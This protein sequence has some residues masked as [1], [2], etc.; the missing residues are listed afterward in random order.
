MTISRPTPHQPPAFR[1]PR[2]SILRI[3][4]HAAVACA[5]LTSSVAHAVSFH[6]QSVTPRCAQ[7]GTTVEVM[8]RGNCL[9]EPREVIFYRPG[10][11]AVDISC[12]K[13]KNDRWGPVRCRFEIA[14]DCPLGEHPFRL[15]T[16]TQLTTLA[17]FHVTPYPT[18]DEVEKKK[19]TNDTLETAVNVAANVTVRGM[20]DKGDHGDVDLYKVPVVPGERL[21]VEVDSVRLADV[22]YGNSEFDVAVRILD[23]DGR[24]LAANDDNPLHVQDPIVAVRIPGVPVADPHGDHAFVEVRRQAFAAFDRMYAVHIGTHRRPLAAYPAGGPAGAPLAV[25]LLGDPLGDAEETI[26]VPADPGPFEY[27]GDGPSSL[28]LRSSPFPNVLEDATL[29]ATPVVA[30]PAA[31]NGILE[32]PGDT[33]AFRMAVKKGDRYRVRVFAAALGSPIDPVIRIRP[34]DAA[35]NPGPVSLQADDATPAERDIFG[36]KFRGGGGLKDIADPSVIWEPKADGDHLLEVLDN[37]GSGA[38]TGVY[39]IEIEPAVDAVHTLLMSTA[40]DWMECP[41]TSSLAVP[42][43]NRWTVNVALPEPQGNAFDGEL[44]IVARGLPPGVRIVSPR[45]PAGQR[46]WPVQFVADPAAI[47]GGAVFSLEARPADPAKVI[48]SGSHQALPFINHSGG[49]A[50]RTVLVDRYVMAVTDPAP[51][52]ISI[53]QPTVPLVRGGELSIPVKITRREGF[54]DPI[55]FQCDWIPKGIAPQPQATIPTGESTA[56]LRI[57][58]ADNAP[59]GGVPLVVAATTTQHANHS[60]LGLG[61]I[62]VS[63]E[64]ATITVAEPFVALASQPESVRR[65]ERK[66]FAWTVEHKSPFEGAATVKLVGLPKGVSVV[67]P[68]PMIT[69]DSKDL[70]FEIEATDEALMGA[71]KGLA[72]EVIVQ[73]AGQEI[74][75]RTGSG[76]LRI[77]PKL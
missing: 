8:M 13:L 10:I 17:T 22:H 30:L 37:E 32:T 46:L 42:Q 2:W 49:D 51:F 16:A 20:L 28:L 7:R 65:G 62:R 29:A 26:V 3:A 12:E 15:R 35:G 33:D 50:W 76:T 31:L 70:V 69:K 39:R 27:F 40:F 72:C 67:E 24:Q 54:D 43:G 19:N 52:S 36:T 5:A 18:L 53:E 1:R 34:L 23:R 66:R 75:Q 47:P 14:A 56:E 4:I 55:D 60:Y 45:V 77:D 41:R 73:A 44:D 68:L 38:A 25:K 57:T 74:H 61:R 58:A 21:S 6:I 59:L 64:I 48:A 71:V 63:S 11:H 9:E